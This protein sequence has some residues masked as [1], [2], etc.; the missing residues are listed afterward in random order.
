MR[1]W[2]VLRRPIWLFD[3]NTHRGVYANT[4][5]MELW[6][7][8]DL[9]ELLSRDFSQ[10]SPAVI[11][12]L[13]R[14]AK[15]TDEG[16]EVSEQWTFYP[17][18]RPVTVQAT[19]S[20]YPLEDGRKVLMFEASPAE[21]QAGERRAVEALRHT[22]TLIT[23]FDADGRAIFTNPAAFAA[24]G[25][26]ELG[27]AERFRDP[28]AGRRLF[29]RALEGEGAGDLCMADTGL[30]L[31]WHQ[32]DA[33]R[34]ID[35]VTGLAGVILNERDVTARIEAEQAR[36]AAEQRAAMAEARR[37]FLS[38]MSH[39]LR[40]PLNA[41]MGFSELL[42]TAAGEPTTRDQARR[43]HEAGQRLVEV[44]EQMI[45]ISNDEGDGVGQ[46][47]GG[48]GP[49]AQFVNAP[50]RAPELTAEE[51]PL[52]VLYVDDNESNRALVTAV[53]SAQGMTCVTA[54]D[55]KSGVAAAAGGE[56]DLILMDIQMPVMNG[57][58]ATRAIRALETR[59]AELPIVA[60]TANTLEEQLQAY[61][62]AGMD[63]L[64]AKPIQLAE[65]VGKVT[66]WG[67]S[68]RAARVGGSDGS[69]VRR[70][71]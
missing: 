16:E 30:G 20:A 13:A 27:F 25:V 55:G 4:S 29:E 58:E 69:G 23:L 37:Q 70:A 6:G 54:E 41:V 1:A 62:D 67:E 50:D 38:D 22:T 66:A 34:V 42:L 18:G 64:I 33:R 2:D 44:V 5:A 36:A 47:E 45:A 51:A 68:S 10:L 43:I 32:M 71:A 28:D 48:A 15:A 56:F 61:A 8:A 35:P 59:V 3:P 26:N 24:Y 14:L 31:R 17:K 65:L 63:D 57:V 53:L 52:K 60:V 12:R 40:T 21:T 39:E 7:A 11:A 46:G 19:I 9:D 49:S